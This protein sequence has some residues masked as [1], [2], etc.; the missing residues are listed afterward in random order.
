MIARLI[1]SGHRSTALGAFGM[2][3][4]EIFF[5]QVGRL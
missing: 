5:C 4:A 1:G 2:K 3:A